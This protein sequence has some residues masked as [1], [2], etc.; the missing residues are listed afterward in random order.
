MKKYLGYLASFCL[1]CFCFT[2]C[3]SDSGTGD[4]P[5]N[6]SSSGSATDYD[7]PECTAK[8][9]GVIRTESEENASYICL[10]GKWKK[11]VDSK[12]D[13]AKC[14]AK[15]EGTVLYVDEEEALYTCVEGEWME[16]DL[17]K[18]DDEDDDDDS[19]DDEK[20]S[21]SDDGDDEGDSDDGDDGDSD[22]G[23]DEGGSG[24]GSDGKSSS[25]KKSSSSGVDG[26]DE[27]GEVIGGDD[28]DDD[29]SGSDKTS[30]YAGNPTD[31][32]ASGVYTNLLWDYDVRAGQVRTSEVLQCRE[33]MYGEYEDDCYG[34]TGGWWFNY[35]NGIHSETPVG[36]NG[37]L[38]L[39]DKYGDPDVNLE[40]GYGLEVTLKAK[41]GEFINGDGDLVFGTG[42]SGIGFDWQK[43][44][45]ADISNYRGIRINYVWIPGTA[46]SEIKMELGWDEDSY[47]WR[48]FR[49]PLKA[50]SYIKDVF[51]DDFVR[52][53]PDFDGYVEG[54]DGVYYVDPD[55]LSIETATTEAKSLKFIMV[56]GSGKQKS[57][58][59][60]IKE[61]YL[62]K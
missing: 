39:R 48:T 15:K 37:N 6:S 58:T 2:A 45:Y 20:P 52:E 60:L 17:S 30:L 25:S 36:S 9:E 54:E 7:A 62:I 55:L 24:T 51:W 19:D 28:G 56:D 8:K 47:T 32:T 44:G 12:D 10:D 59:I 5:S 57:G 4:D 42:V 43:T 50:G 31:L 11:M 23:D 53:D 1:A 35:G 38:Q 40:N 29:V 14:S 41:D 33:E 26:D 46:D 27:G 3:G 34:I 21:G 16:G 49:Y 22:D 13:L 61:L 18:K